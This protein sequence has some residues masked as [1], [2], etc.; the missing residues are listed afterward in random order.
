MQGTVEMGP[1]HIRPNYFEQNQ[2]EALDLD[3]TVLDTLVRCVCW[4]GSG[5]WG[6]MAGGLGPHSAGHTR[7]VCV[8][9]RV[10]VC[11]V[12]EG[13]SSGAPPPPPG[14]GGG[15]GCPSCSAAQAPCPE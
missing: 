11:V 12:R 1:H 4:G 9:A 7:E 15:A 2:A 14:M 10:R 13:V 3:L 5:C 6:V 8:C